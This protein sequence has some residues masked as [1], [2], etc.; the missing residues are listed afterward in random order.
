M[1][2]AEI[3]RENDGNYYIYFQI[4]ELV[5]PYAKALVIVNE[6]TLVKYLRFRT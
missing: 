4:N 6:L 1:N 2:N 3:K 5:N